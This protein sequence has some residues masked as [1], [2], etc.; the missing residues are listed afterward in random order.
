M[1]TS[2]DQKP[3]WGGGIYLK[4]L[5]PHAAGP[6]K[7]QGITRHRTNNQEVTRNSK[8]SREIAKH[9]RKSQK[10][11]VGLLGCFWVVLGSDILIALFEAVLRRLVYAELLF[12]F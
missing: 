8:E 12:H 2:Y 11:V 3:S 10:A 4:G 1:V 7:Q 5:R 6:E 9:R